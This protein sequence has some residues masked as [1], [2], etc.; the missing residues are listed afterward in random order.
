M[1]CLGFLASFFLDV[2]KGR[3]GWRPGLAAREFHLLLG[4]SYSHGF[5]TGFF[6]CFFLV[7][8]GAA[9]RARREQR[10]RVTTS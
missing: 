5:A 6:L 1:A 8:A 9:L 10:T 7:L 3:V 4:R 2:S